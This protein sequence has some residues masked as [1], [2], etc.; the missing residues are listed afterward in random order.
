M[1]VFTLSHATLKEHLINNQVVIYSTAYKYGDVYV[2]SSCCSHFCCVQQFH[3]IWRFSLS[4]CN[5]NN[6]D[7]CIPALFSCSLSLTQLLSLALWFLV[8]KW[9]NRTELSLIS[10]CTYTGA[11]SSWSEWGSWS[12]C[13]RT[14]NGGTRIRQRTCTNGFTCAGSNI[15]TEQ[16]NTNQCSG[17][18][19]DQFMNCVI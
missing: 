2:Q 6:T 12:S 1:I 11:A 18:S 19:T 4:R 15:D 7:H 9:G 13:S 16:C 17:T 14:C 3:Q 10:H 5:Y 8:V